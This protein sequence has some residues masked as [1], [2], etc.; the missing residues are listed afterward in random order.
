[1]LTDADKA[2]R[3]SRISATDIR[4]IAG[5]G[6]G[7]AHDV[8]AEKFGLTPPEEESEAFE[9][10]HL[11]EE[12]VTMPVLA[13]RKGLHLRKTGTLKHR[14]FDWMC[15]TTDRLAATRPDPNATPEYVCEGKN[16]GMWMVRAWEDEEDPDYVPEGVV[17]Q[18]QWQ[19]SVTGIPRA[20]VAALLGGSR[21]HIVELQHSDE[22]HLALID[23]GERFWKDH[24]L[25]GKKPEHD[26]SKAASEL[27]KRM[28]PR[29]GGGMLQASHEANTLA[30]QFIQ[31]QQAAKRDE[32]LLERCKGAL[33]EMIGNSEGMVGD[34]WKATWKTKASNGPNWRAVAEELGATPEL[35][36]KHTAAG[37]R[38][39]LLKP[40]APG[41]K[42][43]RA[44]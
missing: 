10:G 23:I 30:H 32:E 35:I 9:L 24:I 1:M 27:I 44:A 13:K 19:M 40:T 21:V 33:Q 28:F 38:M 36:A 14:I 6:F 5:L 37:S 12:H 29:S 43:A 7:T 22:L 41:L 8:F 16:V 31:A 25:T 15:A 34:G 3:K 42:K 2:I 4:R 18:V 17:A 26:G 11:I 39:F 20:Y